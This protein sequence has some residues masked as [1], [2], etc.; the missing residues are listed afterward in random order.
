MQTYYL[1]IDIGASGGRH[2][3]GSVV[4]DKICLEEVY[5]F[6]NGMEY[7]NGSLCWNTQ[8]IFSEILTGMKKCREI[9][10]VPVSVGI[11]TWGVDFVLLDQEDVLVGEAVGYRDHRTEGMPEELEKQISSQELYERTGIRSQIYNTIYQLMALKKHR[12]EQLEAAESLLMTPDYYHFL[13]T[14]IKKQ[15]YTIASTSQL[16]NV[17][18]RSWDYELID[19]LGLPG[20]L[21]TKLSPPGTPVGNLKPEIR[22]LMGYDCMVVA[23]ASHDTAS[24]V[25][26]VPSI[27]KDILYISSGTWSLMGIETDE[28]NCTAESRQAGFTNEG[29][30]GYRYRFLKNIMGLWMIQSVRR[31]LDAGISYSALCEM[32]SKEKIGSMVD[33]NDMNFLS[34]DSMTEAVKQFCLKTKQQ[35]PEGL[36]QMAAVIYNSLAKCYEA[37]LEEIE[38]LTGKSYHSIHIIGGGS[39]AKYLNELTSRYTGRRVIPGPAEAT[40]IGNLISQMLR[41]H[42]FASLEEARSIISVSGL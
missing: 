25:A 38:R 27:E 37:S 4:D 14:G 11:D 33:C 13:L 32:A 42:V 29:G 8:G 12:P 40:A 22:E 41:D 31:E 10:K 17:H 24:A 23:P 9:G 34:P 6:D 26:A 5:R 18:T 3:L 21:F 2:I 7:K 28:P 20:K 36:A 35:I 1:A 15:E 30:Y 19:Q 16:V 39:N